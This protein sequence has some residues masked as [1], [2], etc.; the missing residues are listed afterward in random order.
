MSLDLTWIASS[1]RPRLFIK[2]GTDQWSNKIWVGPSTPRVWTI[3]NGLTFVTAIPSIGNDYS[4]KLSYSSILTRTMKMAISLLIQSIFFIFLIKTIHFRNEII[5][6]RT[7]RNLIIFNSV[8]M[9]ER[10]EKKRNIF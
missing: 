5:I 8:L 6:T 9:N 3:C 7:K 2:H 1:C 10:M 4:S